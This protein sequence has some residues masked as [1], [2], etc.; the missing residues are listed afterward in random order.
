METGRVLY[1]RKATESWVKD[2]D[3]ELSAALILYEHGKY[4][5]A[6]HHSQQCVEK[7]LKALILENGERLEKPHDIVEMLSRTRRIGWQVSL[8]LAD[9]VFLNSIYK[10]RYPTEEGLLLLG[11]PAKTDGERATQAARQF[12]DGLRTALR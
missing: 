6:C 4:K 2:A 9:A 1:M 5:G 12:M 11:E 7:G 10:G 3:D 8:P